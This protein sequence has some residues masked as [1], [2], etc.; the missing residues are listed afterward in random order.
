MEI[1]NTSKNRLIVV[2]IGVI[3]ILFVFGGSL[4]PHKTL[5]HFDLLNEIYLPYANEVKYP[6]ISDHYAA[7]QIQEMYPLQKWH[8]KQLKDGYFPLWN[9]YD[10][11]GLPYHENSV[12]LPL[13]PFKFLLLFLPVDQVFDLTIILHFLFAFL[14]MTYYLS[15]HNFSLLSILF[16]AT[17]WALCAFFVNNY[18]RE[19]LIA[20]IGLIPLIVALLDNLFQQQDIKTTLL[21]GAGLGFTLLISGPLGFFIYLLVIISRFIGLLLW[22]RNYVSSRLLGYFILGGIIGCLIAAVNILGTVHAFLTSFR[23][24]SGFL[25]YQLSFNWLTAYISSFIAV[26]INSFYPFIIGSKDSLDILKIFGLNIQY[27]SYFSFL[28]ILIVPFGVKI[29]RKPEFKWLLIL[30]LLFLLSIS[31]LAST[32]MK[33][34]LL[35]VLTFLLIVVSSF[36]LDKLLNMSSVRL[37]KVGVIFSIFSLILIII[38][39]VRHFIV[40]HNYELLHDQVTLFIQNRIDG[41]HLER[42]ADW[43]MDA[44]KRFLDLQL[45]TNKYNIFLL[46]NIFSFSILILIGGI[47][48]NRKFIIFALVL[49]IV[50]PIYYSIDNVHIIDK[51]KYPPPYLTPGMEV[52]KENIRFGRVLIVRKDMHARLLLIKNQLDEFGINHING[53]GSFSPLRSCNV[54][55]GQEN[56]DHPLW[57]ELGITHLVWS[58]FSTIDSSKIKNI[59]YSEEIVIGEKIGDP[60]RCWIVSNLEEEKDPEKS[61]KKLKEDNRPMGERTHYVNILPIGYKQDSGL[62]GNAEIISEKENEVKIVANVEKPGLLILSDT[63]YTGWVAE[64]S[65]IEKP[66]LRVDGALRGVWL[67]PGEHN[68]K[69]T[70]RPKLFYSGAAISMTTVLTIVIILILGAFKKVNGKRNLKI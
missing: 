4:L 22:E 2:S 51:T 47:I 28:G 30:A 40:I 5:F 3:V 20:P 36:G 67:P 60:K 1:V 39:F 23:T 55:P 62:A 44:A 63:W 11:G 7:D 70:Y 34:R 65:G 64:V 59:I 25:G 56:L 13:H 9:P 16:G 21:F 17:S 48:K 14:G 42:Y 24:Y 54:S 27:S 49:C 38:F 8:A 53:T 33:G 26:G 61:I 68:I 69:F 46:T 35:I 52:L 57:D 32:L 12:R 58:K 66:I 45:I 29:I 50:P 15:R 31:P 6:D 43:K 41:Y 18:P 10:Q 37:K 19:G